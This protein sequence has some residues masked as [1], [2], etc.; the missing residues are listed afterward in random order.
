[1]PITALKGPY[2]PRS[3][4]GLR[5]WL[6]NFASVV[7]RDP[8]AVE[9]TRAD[10]D[11]LVDLAQRFASAYV[12]AK[13]PGTKNKVA[14]EEKN[15]VRRET[16]D[17]VRPIAMLIKRNPAIPR[18]LMIELGIYPPLESQSPIAKPRSAPQLEVVTMGRG[19]HRLRYH[20]AESPSSVAKPYGAVA[21]ELRIV[22]GN[23][24]A[25]SCRKVK[26]VQ[27]I[28]K[29]VFSVKFSA[30]EK[31]QTATYFGRWITQRGKAGAW[32]MPL[33]LTIL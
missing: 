29:H 27:K 19:F 22:V 14:T 28:T 8:S 9:L 26:R 11:A 16:W 7:A 33:A 13:S 23:E 10:A 32:S 1:M 2:I 6:D 12:R 18:P 21:M 5:L 3:D 30:D 4:S 20:N 31:R 24:P 17:T 25:T 15:K